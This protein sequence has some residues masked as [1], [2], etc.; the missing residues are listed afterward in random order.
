MTRIQGTTVRD[1]DSG[2]PER[3]WLRTQHG[4][5]IIPSLNA[6]HFGTGAPPAPEG[7]PDQ[8]SSKSH[9]QKVLQAHFGD[10]LHQQDRLYIIVGS[11]SGQLLHYVRDHAPLPRGSRWL[12]IEPAEILETLERNPSIAPLCDEFVQLVSPDEWLE[13]ANLLQLDAYF[14]IDGVQFER[15]LAALDGTAPDYMEITAALDAHLTAERFKQLAQLN[16][17]PF[18]QPNIL[19]AVDFQGGIDPLQDR[20]EGKTAVI[21]AGGPSLDE[22]VP[23]LLEHRESLFVIAVSRVSARL[24]D[25]GLV[26]D[27]LVT[28]DP[29]PISL[30]VS[31][32]MFDF[33]GKPL[34]I[35]S[36][37]PYPAIA[38]RWPHALLCAGDRVPWEDDALNTDAALPMSGP[39]VTH[40]ATQLAGFMGFTRLIFCGLDLC[41]SPDGRTHATHSSEAAAGPLLDFSAIPVTNNRGESVWTTPDYFAGIEAMSSI[42]RAMPTVEMINPS[43]QAA[44]IE[45]VEHAGL[46][47]I[48]LP[49][50]T[51][52]RRPLEDIRD[53]VTS[54]IRQDDLEA[55]ARSIEAIREELEKV[56]NLAQ[57][58]L[59]SNQAY[60]NLAHPE[61]QK[62]HKRRMQAIDRMFTGRYRRAAKLAQRAATRAIMRSNLPHEFFDLDKAQAERLAGNYYEAIQEEARR[63]R[64]PLELAANRVQ[65][66]LMELDPSV[67]N[68]TLVDR[69]IRF[70]EP[71]RARWLAVNRQASADEITPA[72]KRYAES[73]DSLLEKDRKRNERKRSPRSS[74]RQI[75]RLFSSG[76]R[77]GLAGLQRA[78]EEHRQADVA[79]PYATYARGLVHELDHDP[80][81][82]A[83]SHAEVLETADMEQD[84]ILIEHALL[85]LT[86][87][88]LGAEQSGDALAT[89]QMA[90]NINPAHWR[91]VA[92]LALL[93]NDAET[94]I[95]ALTRHL[96]HFPGDIERVKQVIRLFVALE[97]PDGVAF[98]ERYLD[99]C[100]SEDR[101]ELAGFI[102]DARA[103]LAAGG[104]QGQD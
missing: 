92:R 47:T 72:E 54:D 78:L 93:A 15:S 61:R 5:W 11:D 95:T 3:E 49:D 64:E 96:E 31:R 22:Q 55:L 30:T 25:A 76:R 1:G 75:E 40:M 13:Q 104:T 23:W 70:E 97:I 37:H 59:E 100:S 6:S 44:V 68:A 83:A 32:Q 21:I 2:K 58:G 56:G 57:L 16:M 91:R 86:T 45:G 77:E 12:F 103:T 71:E 10:R 50:T 4:D 79:R 27:I 18:I 85:R 99:Y 41:H 33:P 87:I 34:L 14:H 80:V 51:F 20:F 102:E 35:T 9:A 39:T 7:R 46:D 19:A 48:T 74:L 66:R 69:Y 52:D 26:P 90:A 67:D 38:N 88:N 29:Y 81:A 89:L 24:L 43:S 84:V 28:V 101:A 36:K 98:C 73:I 65:T 8:E 17:A 53:S 42:A 82:A 60:F 94:G 62:R 63:L